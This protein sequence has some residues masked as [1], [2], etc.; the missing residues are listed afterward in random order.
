MELELRMVETEEILSG[1]ERTS[2]RV[3]IPLITVRYPMAPAEFVVGDALDLS[4]GGMFI[5]ASRPLPVGRL[6]PFEIRVVAEALPLTAVGRVMWTRATPGCRNLPTGMGVQFIDIDRRSHDVIRSLVSVRE[7][8][9]Y[10]LGPCWPEPLPVA[11]TKRPL[12]GV[13][14]AEPSLPFLLVTRR[15]RQQ[16]VFTPRRR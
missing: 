4:Q 5:K 14:S 2:R 10:G 8:T 9:I 13:R 1:D 16:S 6:I 7:Q 11:G 3:Q 12:S 15:A